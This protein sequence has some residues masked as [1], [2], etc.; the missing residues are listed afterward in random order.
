MRYWQS[1]GSA[2][3]LAL[4]NLLGD[5]LRFALSAVAIGLSLMLMVF[6]LAFR[7]GARLS[8][9]VYL[10]HAP[11]SVVVMPPGVNSTSAGSA[12][13]L[14]SQTADAVA[15]VPG[16]ASLTPVMLVMGFADLHGT[17]EGIRLV[18]YD[19]ERGGGPWDLAAGRDPKGGNEVVVDRVLADR[20][21]LRLGDTFELT[22]QQLT[23][24]GLSSE[25]ASFSGAYA[26]AEKSLV[27]NLMLAPG[28]S[29]MILI[30]PSPGM[31]PA[32]LLTSLKSIPGTNVLLKKDVMAEDQ[33]I[34]NGI[35][36][37]IIV[38][39]LG[40]AFIVG[41]LIVGM[42]IYTATNERRAE[43]GILKAIGARNS[44]LYEVVASQAFVAGAAGSLLG[45]I[46]AF[47]MR[48]LVLQLKPQFLVVIQPSAIAASVAAA[49]VMALAAS[50]F[51]A[52]DVARLEPAEVFRG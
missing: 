50:L 37:E 36:D 25:T 17:K 18:G 43:Y 20:H 39:M 30:T 44:L 7:E 9:I 34:I 46:F 1:L 47:A 45:V 41:A 14:S 29:S 42:V 28:S 33:A 32:A 21:G 15:E 31:Q 10:E 24:V 19:L 11:G 35:V 16:V 8:S 48:W 4:R 23:I 3:H 12:Q 5:R 26:F 49:I 22:G 13:F 27:E 40:A 6:L 38:V 2:L 52:R 51:P